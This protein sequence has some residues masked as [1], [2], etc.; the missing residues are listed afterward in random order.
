MS[1]SKN[2]FL[3]H[4]SV[5]L[6]DFDCAIDLSCFPLFS[7]NAIFSCFFHVAACRINLLFLSLGG[8]RSGLFLNL[9][10]LIYLLLVAP[11]LCC[12]TPAFPGCGDQGPLFIAVHELLAEVASPVAEHRL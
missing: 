2:V 7:L 3:Q 12:C 6:H 4:V 8:G 1:L 11:G 9:Y 5:W 10:L